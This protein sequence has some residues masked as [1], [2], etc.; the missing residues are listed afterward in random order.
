MDPAYDLTRRTGFTPELRHVRGSLFVSSLA[1]IRSR[2][3]EA[4]YRNA[5]EPSAEHALL[6]T[7][8]ATWLPL[9][10]AMAHYAACESAMPAELAFT[11]GAASGT[12]VQESILS[13]LLKVATGAGATPWSAFSH[14]PRLWSRIFDGAAA[15]VTKTGPKD[16]LVS[17][18]DFPLARFAYFRNAFRGSHDAIVRLLASTVF[19]NEVPRH[20][21]STSF[22]LS[23]AWA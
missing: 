10:F 21:T 6:G 1:E 11:I 15:T 22:R 13:P 8:T 16:A 14:Y 4:A 9:K 7:I 2:G 19:V 18:E 12:R 23:V 5:L 17:I 3:F 20:T